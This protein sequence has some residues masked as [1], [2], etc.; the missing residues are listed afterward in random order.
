MVKAIVFDC[1][2]VLER[3]LQPNRE[4]FEYIEKELKPHYKIGIISNVMAGF[5]HM[6]FSKE[7]LALF[8][9]IILSYQTG[10]SK[11]DPAIYKMSLKNLGVKP[12]EA[13]FLD[14]QERLC[15]GARAVGMQAI[16]FK[17]FAQAKKDLEKLL[18]CKT[19]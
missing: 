6:M 15:E 9:D 13:V 3:F 12:E 10:T 18:S 4:L 19:T 14:D 11:P 1:F 2:G 17:D 5:I 7:Q 16:C 8:D